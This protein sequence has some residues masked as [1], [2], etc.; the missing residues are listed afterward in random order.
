MKKHTLTVEKTPLG[1]I[2]YKEAKL[3]IECELTQVTTVQPDDFY[4]EEGKL[5]IVEACKEIEAYRKLVIG[6]ITNAWVKK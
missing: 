2:S 1:N 5:F 3:I 6:K 4:S